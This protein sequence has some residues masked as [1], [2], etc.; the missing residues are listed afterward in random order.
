ML[1]AINERRGGGNVIKN[2][3]RFR[4]TFYFKVLLLND[5]NEDENIFHLKNRRH[6]FDVIDHIALQ[7]E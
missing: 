4:K 5:F 1:C 6:N 2:K 7:L 3:V